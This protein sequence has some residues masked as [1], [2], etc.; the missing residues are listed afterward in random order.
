[1]RRRKAEGG[2]MHLF[3]LTSL[4]CNTSCSRASFSD[5]DS[6]LPALGPKGILSKLMTLN[7]IYNLKTFKCL[8]LAQTSPRCTP[9]PYIQLSAQYLFLGVS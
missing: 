3:P 2:G 6:L 8:C 1:M 7:I 4:K 5:L 9:A